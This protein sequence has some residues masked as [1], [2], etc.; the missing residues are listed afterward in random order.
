MTRALTHFLVITFVAVFPA[1]A[2]DEPPARVGHVSFVSGNLAFHAPN[3]AGRVITTRNAWLL[4]T[5][6]L[7]T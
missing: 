4:P 5:S 3:G 7:P 1:L 2:R 6:F